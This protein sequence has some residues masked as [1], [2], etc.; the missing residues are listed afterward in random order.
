MLQLSI[1]SLAINSV[2]QSFSRQDLSIETT[3]INGSQETLISYDGADYFGSIG[4]PSVPVKTL[5]ISVPYN[6]VNIKLSYS[7][8]KDCD[9]RLTSP[10]HL[11]VNEFGDSTEY[12]KGS[13]FPLENAVID[14]IGYV[15][16]INKIVTICLCPVS[17]NLDS[18][19]LTFYSN[20]SA[21]LTWDTCTDFTNETIKPI[22]SYATDK[23]EQVYR[24]PGL[25]N[26][27]DVE[28]NKPLLPKKTKSGSIEEARY[29]IVCPEEFCNDLERLAAYRRLKGYTTKVFA[30]EDI[31]ADPKYAEGDVISGI[32]DDAGK[33]R[34]FLTDAYTNRG[35]RYVLLAG[36]Y[37]AMPIRYGYSSDPK[38][39]RHNGV[40]TDLYFSELNSSWNTTNSGVYGTSDDNL[41]YHPEIHI[42]RIPF[43]NISEIHDF[44]DKLKIYEHNPGMGDSNYLSHGFITRQDN[45]LMSDNHFK[46][47]WF[48]SLKEFYNGNNL[49]EIISTNDYPLGQDVINELNSTNYGFLSFVGHGSPYGVAVNKIGGDVYDVL[50]LE[51]QYSA[52]KY[53]PKNGL[54]NLT[55]KNFP[56]WSYSVSCETMPFDSHP[57]DNSNIYG[58]NVIK[59]F[60]E[61]YVLG[62]DYG[63]VLFLGHTRE[64]KCVDG[65]KLLKAF[66]EN[67]KRMYADYLGEDGPEFPITA[68]EAMSKLRTTSGVF[69]EGRLS[70]NLLGDPV[71]P[72]W[73]S[74]L[75]K[76]TYIKDDSK[77]NHFLVDYDGTQHQ[78]LIIE[79]LIGNNFH[80]GTGLAGKSYETNGRINVLQ[81]LEFPNSLP[82]IFPLY[83]QNITFTKDAYIVAGDVYCGLHVN[84]NAPTGPVQLSDSIS[85]TI[86]SLGNVSII[87]GATGLRPHSKLTIKADGDVNIFSLSMREN[88]TLVIEANTINIEHLSKPASA[89]VKLTERNPRNRVAARNVSEE[90]K[91]MLV[92]GRTW[93]YTT[94]HRLYGYRDEHHDYSR[95]SENGLS[96]GPEVEIEGVKWHKINIVTG[97]SISD[98]WEYN[99]TPRTIGYMRE[100]GNK[101]FTAY[102]D[103]YNKPEYNYFEGV[104]EYIHQYTNLRYP[105]QLT[106]E[107]KNIGESYIVG[108]EN[109]VFTTVTIKNI[110]K[111]INSGVEYTLYECEIPSG[112][113][114]SFIDGL[115]CITGRYFI[116][117]LC[118]GVTGINSYE[119]PQLRY[120]TD[121]DSSII[122]EGIGG[123]KLWEAT[124]VDN[125]IAD[126]EESYL[127]Y[128]LQGMAIDEPTTPGIYIRCSR[129]DNEKV[130][131]R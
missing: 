15:D 124:G 19:V 100:D 1:V 37:P 130:I 99:T 21:S 6:A 35:T 96:V 64:S 89:V 84:E 10:V 102:F 79:Q 70:H 94:T 8:T 39:N 52:S 40:P 110:S 120:I 41:D 111:C 128:N 58:Y 72:L 44:I 76:A 75:D 60:G 14:N 53:E 46:E 106:Y 108:D 122:Y 85:L 29:I 9:I 28:K 131:I 73:V 86:E 67:L 101:I 30:I 69:H 55:N 129:S 48:V 23:K 92:E 66:F 93:W 112:P 81:S 36:K 7:L 45:G 12:F 105:V 83:L 43:S 25:V 3:E 61:S 20:V 109:Y 78:C 22:V 57:D 26:P 32:N 31:L 71:T 87:T 74:K 104:S 18:N 98:V 17:L 91:P 2:S 103:D 38:I 54:N 50:G 114:A 4:E 42:G 59:N 117:P 107:Y 95:I 68:G 11:N 80:T 13:K 116:D 88:T 126:G 113:D 51:N 90:H 16:G 49:R 125:V 118:S 34:A 119:Y 63:G 56:S 97:L 82:V 27:D 33:L 77:D 24:L 65:E 47:K 62:K 121:Q 115:G 5:R 127:W 123:Y